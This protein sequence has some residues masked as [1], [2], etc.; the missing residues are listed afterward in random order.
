M[1]VRQSDINSTKAAIAKYPTKNR[2]IIF[3]EDRIESI[4][5]TGF[6]TT[7]G[8]KR[9]ESDLVGQCGNVGQF[10]DFLPGA[11]KPS[12][13]TYLQSDSLY[14]LEG[15]GG[16]GFLM[17]DAE[18]NLKYASNARNFSIP[19]SVGSDFTLYSYDEG[20]VLHE[21]TKAGDG[22]ERVQ[23]K[24]SRQLSAVLS[25]ERTSS[26]CVNFSRRGI[27]LPSTLVMPRL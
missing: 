18:G 13:Y 20:G 22:T 25:M 26:I 7:A 15:T 27:L 19:S 21:I 4:P 3:I 9:R 8:Q 14:A 17:L 2:E 11:S 23:I 12:E 1:T 16:L 10:T 6:L 5:T 24:S